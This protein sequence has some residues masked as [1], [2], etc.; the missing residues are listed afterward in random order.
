[1][2]SRYSED[3]PEVIKRRIRKGIPDALRG[4]VW[5]I[6]LSSRCCSDIY[7]SK[8]VTSWVYIIYLGYY[9]YLQLHHVVDESDDYSRSGGVIDRD[10]NRTY[11]NHEDYEVKNGL[12]QE[13]LRRVLYAFADHDKEVDIVNFVL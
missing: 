3:K 9:E 1:M 2:I 5:S 6:L 4:R 7:S 11:P 8:H 10:I 12:G 13:T